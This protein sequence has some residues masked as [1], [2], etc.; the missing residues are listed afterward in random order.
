MIILWSVTEFI[1][2]LYQ[3]LIG[4]FSHCQPVTLVCLWEP[5]HYHIMRVF[6]HLTMLLVTLKDLVLKVGVTSHSHTHTHTHTH[7]NGY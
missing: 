7:T 3:N 5:I 4:R 6:H 1:L 2:S